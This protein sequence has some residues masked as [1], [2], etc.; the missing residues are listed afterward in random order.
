MFES[1]QVYEKDF[2]NRSKIHFLVTEGEIVSGC[3]LEDIAF[4]NTP[5]PKKVETKN[6]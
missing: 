1:D 6:Y 5:P 2:I 4:L 3:Q